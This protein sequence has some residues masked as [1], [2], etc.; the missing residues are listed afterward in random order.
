MDEK[1]QMQQAERDVAYIRSQEEQRM[2]EAEQDEAVYR[3]KEEERR[4]KDL[5]KYELMKKGFESFNK[6]NYER[7]KVSRHSFPM[8]ATR[9]T[10]FTRTLRFETLVEVC[11]VGDFYFISE[12]DTRYGGRLSIVGKTDRGY[13]LIG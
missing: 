12:K 9:P 10:P 4:R 3:D 1:T 7:E 6:L 11:N 13:E 5:E 2:R 8:K